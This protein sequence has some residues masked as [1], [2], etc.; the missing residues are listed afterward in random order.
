MKTLKTLTLFATFAALAAAQ[1]TLVTQSTITAAMTA[2]QNYAVLASATNVAAARM[3]LIDSELMTV[4]KY[5]A[6]GL[7]VP[8][9]RDNTGKKSSHASGAMTLVGLPR[10][11][12]AY[13]P[14]GSCTAT[15]TVSTPWITI[16][17]SAIGGDARQWLCSTV[18]NRW[19]PGWNNDFVPAQPTAAV[20]SAAGLITPSGQLFHITGALAITGFNIPLGF[21]YGS[22]TV[23]PDGAF[24]T[25]TANNIAL[26]STGVVSKPLTFTYDANSGKFYPS[27]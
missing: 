7:T 10:A 22:F 21:A 27:Y 11:F 20:A 13:D 2:T 6:S 18:V 3:I 25:T 14:Y 1:A 9:T 16:A 26:A 15:T 23:I 17:T 5:Y 12:A 4:G 24:T 19:V 8:V